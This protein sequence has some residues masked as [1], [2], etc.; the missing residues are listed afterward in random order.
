MPLLLILHPRRARGI[1]VRAAFALHFYAFV[2]LLFCAALLF[3]DLHK[4]LGGQG[5]GSPSFDTWMTALLLC[6]YIAYLYAALGRVY[7][8]ARLLLAVRALALGV[9]VAAIVPGYRFVI[10]LI[11]LYTTR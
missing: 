7:P 3:A 1:V 2:L 5:L 10:F 4:A 6:G 11:T 8:S 9:V